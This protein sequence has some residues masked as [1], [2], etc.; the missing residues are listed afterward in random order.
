MDPLD[1]IA[2]ALRLS[3]SSKEAE[4]RSAVGRAY[5]G[6]FHV[7]RRFLCDCGLRF[8][9]KDLYAAE[10]HQKIQYCLSE[11]G[12]ADAVIARDGLKTLRSQRNEADYDLD[13]T[14]FRS[15][16]NVAAMVRVAPAIVDAMQRCRTEPAFSEARA[17]IRIYARDVLRIAVD[18]G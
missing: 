5:Y 13:T 9:S 14:T 4:L 15:P 3:S 11:S 17:K 2:L 7:A 1:F 16:G 12:N 18:E 8:S 6:A 10:I